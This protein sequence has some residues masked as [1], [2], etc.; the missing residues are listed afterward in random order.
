MDFADEHA[1]LTFLYYALPCC[2]IHIHYKKIS[3]EEADEAIS[4]VASNRLPSQKIIDL[5]VKAK[6]RCG[7]TAQEMK[8][9][10][11][12]AVAVRHAFC[13]DHDK[14]VDEGIR[15]GTCRC[16]DRNARKRSN[17][18]EV[19]ELGRLP[20]HQCRY[21]NVAWPMRLRAGH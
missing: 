15:D 5:F 18:D 7:T 10:K 17:C 6:Y 20:G 16:T 12:D 8:K 19:V 11:I 2:S 3:K 21:R 13:F 1:K 9:E 14:Y 4:Q